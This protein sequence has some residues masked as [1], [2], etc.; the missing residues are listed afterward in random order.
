MKRSE[1]RARLEL[2]FM[3]QDVEGVIVTQAG[4][5]KESKSMLQDLFKTENVN[6]IYWSHKDLESQ[7]D[8]RRGL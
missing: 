1:I 6:D 5:F 8:N 3:Q 2:A 4:E 7:L